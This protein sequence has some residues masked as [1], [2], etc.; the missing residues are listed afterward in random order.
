MFSNIITE[1]RGED[2]MVRYYCTA[3][4]GMQSFLVEEVKKKLAA[5][6]V[7]QI[8][9]KVLFSSSATIQRVC[10]LKAAERLF[11]LLKQDSPVG[12]ST[13]TSPA[14]T[15]SVLRSRLLGDRRQWLSA[16]MTWSRLQRELA[17]SRSAVTTS[18]THGVRE[19]G[20][21]SERQ[22]DEGKKC[23]QESRKRSHSFTAEESDEKRQRGREQ[24][25]RHA[26][27]LEKDDDVKE[28]EEVCANYSKKDLEQNV[29]SCSKNMKNMDD[30]GEDAPL[31]SVENVSFRINCKCSGSLSRCAG[32][33][34]VSKVMGAG[35]SKL[36][37]WKADLK[38]PKLEISV[39]LSDDYCLLGIP[40]TRLPLANRSYIKSTG[41]RSTIAWAMASLAQIQPG[42]RVV[43]PMCGVGTI[44][45]EAANEHKAACF[46][47]VD[48]DDGQLQKADENI[49]F[50]ELQG[51]VHLLKASSKALPLPSAS[52]DA[53]VC[54]L[55][56]GRKF[57]TR[58]NMA[59]NLPL[60]LS[61]M[62][63]VLCVGGTLVVLL[64]PQLSCLLKKLLSHT[65][66]G[67]KG[68]KEDESQT[69][70]KNC[71]VSSSEQQ[72]SQIQ[73]SSSQEALTI[74]SLR[75]QTT[76]RVSLGAI[77]GL[78][79]KYIKTPD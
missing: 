61:E 28:S 1:T 22:S 55:P 77:D 70:I 16:V 25:R 62:E 11:L 53:V 76:L 67:P 34:E 14:K 68:N 48:I 17:A 59:D 58:V 26:L 38:N 35:L 43:D 63:R 50:A 32:A 23:H 27:E 30:L 36:L 42:F 39:F 60:I 57:S 79:H 74:S 8:P 6:D 33:Q 54:D 65:H 73:S 64:S 40:L 47:G 31:E 46:L 51:R 7:H 45:I 78:I 66:S 37:G 21:G 19:K 41:L 52:V 24:I 49:A 29:E 13:H 4:N 44:L 72:I 10:D 12:M 18:N 20:R 75:H 56:F 9:G 15:A 3:G 71:L 2:T 69:G 5:R